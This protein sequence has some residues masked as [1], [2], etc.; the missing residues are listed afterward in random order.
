ML[1]GKSDI[2]SKFVD[3]VTSKN[4]DVNLHAKAIPFFLR[5]GKMI[6]ALK[7]VILLNEKY[8]E[9]PK[10][11]PSTAKFLKAWLSLDDEAKLAQGG[12]KHF[13]E[14][15]EKEVT[16]LGGPKT[17]KDLPKWVAGKQKESDDKK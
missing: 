2:V 4:I 13:I 15:V 3:K 14:T 8:P 12:G 16:Q 1:E 10:T 11:I 9:H 7:S 6:K 17:D 5:Q